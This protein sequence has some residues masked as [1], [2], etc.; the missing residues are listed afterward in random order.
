LEDLGDNAMDGM[1]DALLTLSMSLLTHRLVG[2]R[3]ESAILSYAAARGLSDTTG[4][5]LEPSSITSYLYGL[6]WYSQVVVLGHS[7][8]FFQRNETDRGLTS[9]T[10]EMSRRRLTNT[11]ETPG[12]YLLTLHL[13][14]RK[15]AKNTPAPAKV[16]WA[17]SGNKIFYEDLGFTMTELRSFCSSMLTKAEASFVRDLLLSPEEDTSFLTVLLPRSQIGMLTDSFSTSS[18]GYSFFRLPLNNLS[19][20]ASFGKDKLRQS[21]A[22]SSSFFYSDSTG[23]HLH[24][25]TVQ[26]YHTKDDQ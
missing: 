22:L 24:S 15:A 13:Y 2:N 3:F 1:K 19:R 7:F 23:H 14:M 6:I 17:D 18:F 10:A 8:R 9:V 11:W 21:P 25:S 20:F 26:A 5:W 12:M 4:V 16:L